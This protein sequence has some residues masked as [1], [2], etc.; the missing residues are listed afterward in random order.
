LIIRR[1]VN[2]MMKKL[3]AKAEIQALTA[4]GISFISDTYLPEKIKK[5]DFLD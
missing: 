2:E 3:D 1:E 5:K 4:R